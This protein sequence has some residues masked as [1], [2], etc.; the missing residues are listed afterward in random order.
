MLIV[1]Q[2]CADARRTNTDEQL[3]RQRQPS[4]F[5]NLFA[6]DSFGCRLSW[7][8]WYVIGA[9]IPSPQIGSP[10]R[11]AD[12]VETREALRGFLD[13]VQTHDDVYFV[14]NQQVSRCCPRAVGSFCGHRLTLRCTFLEQ[15]LNWMR[16][17]V[18]ASQM[19]SSSIVAC[20]MPDVPADL[21][22]CNGIPQNQVGLLEQCAF[23]DFPW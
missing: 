14:T 15:L 12:P 18:P 10:A 22:I 9:R 7:R 5:W 21:K 20:S 2:Q 19:R 23:Y 8:G 6:P 4:T 11:I 13:W 1:S 16:N 17:P 3:I